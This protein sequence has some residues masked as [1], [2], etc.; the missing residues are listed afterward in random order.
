VAVHGYCLMPNHAHLAL[1]SPDEKAL[2]KA[3]GRRTGGM[4]S[5]LLHLPAQRASLAEPF[6]LLRAG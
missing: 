5:I 4:R 1:T 6:F 3:V 2:A